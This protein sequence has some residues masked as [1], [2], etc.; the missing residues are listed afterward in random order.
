MHPA[1]PFCIDECVASGFDRGHLEFTKDGPGCQ[2]L[3]VHFVVE[4]LG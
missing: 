4:K 3:D 2:E 1:D